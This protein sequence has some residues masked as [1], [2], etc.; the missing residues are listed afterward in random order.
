M[1]HLFMKLLREL[2]REPHH[3]A[4][5]AGLTVF[6]LLIGHY[7]K[8]ELMAGWVY[9]VFENLFGAGGGQT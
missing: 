5:A 3:Y 8:A 1:W 4:T 2:H 6:M 9:A 7:E